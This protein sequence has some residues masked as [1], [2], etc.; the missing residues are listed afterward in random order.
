MLNNIAVFQVFTGSK[1]QGNLAAVLLVSELPDLPQ[2][3][4][5]QQ[6]FK[7]SNN[8]TVAYVQYSSSSQSLYPIRWFQND[9]QVK[10]CGHASLA[11]AALLYRLNKEDTV[12]FQSDIESFEVI[13][14]HHGFCLELP[15]ISLVELSTK[16]LPFVTQRASH[17]KREDGYLIVACF[18]SADVH[19]FSLTEPIQ[20]ALGQ[21]A[22]IV[23][24]LDSQNAGQIIFRY[25]APQYGVEEDQATGSAGP[26]LWEFWHRIINRSSIQC[27]QVS[28][29][30]GFFNI[31]ASG[32]RVQ[33]VGSV[34]TVSEPISNEH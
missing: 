1:A 16:R 28:P 33:V 24:A 7:I 32:E 9:Y 10:R 18:N 30:G 23:S 13:H 15:A 4:N 31:L 8:M 25:F 2:H 20:S 29:R 19:N 34:K 5:Y 26:V 22:L 14:E 12:V 17:T 6:R 11:A 27:Q 3:K 21:R